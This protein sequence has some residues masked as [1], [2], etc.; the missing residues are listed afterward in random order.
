MS[1]NSVLSKLRPLSECRTRRGPNR[2]KMRLIKSGTTVQA[3]RSEVANT[4][5]HWRNDPQQSHDL[6][7][8]KIPRNQLGRRMSIQSK[9]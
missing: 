2:E 6:F 7:R 4:S 5:H 8:A 3:F 9:L 1:C